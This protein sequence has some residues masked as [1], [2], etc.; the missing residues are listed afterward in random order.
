MAGLTGLALVAT[1]SPGWAGAPAQPG[2]TPAQVAQPSTPCGRSPK[3]KSFQDNVPQ[4]PVARPDSTKHG[5]DHYTLTAHVGTHS[6]SPANGWPAVTTLGYSAPGATSD[7][8]GPTIVTRKNR[9]ADVKM[10]NELRAGTAIFPFDQPNNNNMLTV[11]RHGGL[12]PADSDGGPEPIGVEVPPG[13]SQTQ[14]YPNNQAAAPLWYHDH[15]DAQ[16]S[17][18][19]YEGLVGFIPNTDKRE[20]KFGPP[21]GD[22]AK[23]YMLQDKSFNAHMRLCYSH[24]DPEF[25]GDL[26]VVNGLV[27]PKQAVEPRRYSFTFI[28]ASDSRFYHLSL[29]QTS[30]STASTPKMTVVASDSGYLRHPAK[31]TQ[32]GLLVT[33]GERY[34]VV[35][36]FTGHNSQNWVLAN[37]AAA[38]FPGPN[39]AP[40]IPQL[41]RFDVGS[42]T[43]SKDSSQVPSTIKET[44]NAGDTDDL[45]KQARVRTVQ[46][47]EATPGVPQLGDQNQL[48][49]YL[50][51]AT[52]TPKLNS[53]EVWA[54]RNHS[55][56]AHPIHLHQVEIRLIGRWPAQFDANGRPTSVGAFQPP[57]PYE[58]GPKDTFVAP[59]GFITA[60]VVTFTIKG[61]AVWHCH[62]L[63]HEDGASTGG[64]DEMMRPLVIGNTVQ[65]QLPKIH[66]LAQLVKV[67]RQ[68]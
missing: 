31:V 65:T 33:P 10:I 22:F 58:T 27:A 15:S 14:H 16:T 39:A 37:D 60:W 40:R 13:G 1:G 57:A 35:V 21:N 44:N 3:V 46:A 34:T 36:D 63:S 6:F 9:P 12:Q 23:A 43:S 68:P 25:F 7:Y 59:P 45:L 62:I 17:Y 56:D 29:K 24:A 49:N 30:G 19:M 61:S 26:P 38:P 32:S 41:M 50:D 52:E 67:I 48:L 42:S 18:H 8:L 66:N 47:G 20:P 54:M 2:P 28:N 64:A 5:R 51:P 11:H 55:P 4:P 53:T